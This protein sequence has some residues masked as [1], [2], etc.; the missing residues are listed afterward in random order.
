MRIVL[1][2][3]IVLAIALVGMAQQNPRSNTTGILLDYSKLHI[4]CTVSQQEATDVLVWRGSLEVRPDH[5]VAFKIVYPEGVPNKEL[6]RC[7]QQISDSATT[8]KYFESWAKS[9]YSD[10]DVS[11]LW[12][13]YVG[14]KLVCFVGKPK[15]DTK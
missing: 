14:D 6:E 15:G 5:A 13:I 9:G 12:E 4:R 2:T 11:R 10:A 8:Q 1:R 7:I 3:L